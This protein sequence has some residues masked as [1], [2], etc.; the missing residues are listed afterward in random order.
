MAFHQF[1]EA[2]QL[3]GQFVE[4]GSLGSREPMALTDRQLVEQ[5]PAQVLL[6]RLPRLGPADWSRG[7]QLRPRR[8]Q[9]TGPPWSC[10]TQA[11]EGDLEPWSCPGPSI[12]RPSVSRLQILALASRLTA[13]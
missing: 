12:A 3:V 6:Q 1:I 2:I 11:G 8:G 5:A 10:R 7:Q 9:R 4:A 13:R